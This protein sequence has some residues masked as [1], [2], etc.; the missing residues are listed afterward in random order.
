MSA[1]AGFLPLTVLHMILLSVCPG[2]MTLYCDVP[3][4]RVYKAKFGFCKGKGP[5]DIDMAL[6]NTNCK[7][8]TASNVV[9]V[10]FV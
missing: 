3:T 6:G 1:G 8:H 9:T 2:G 4:L 5:K 7:V 10:V